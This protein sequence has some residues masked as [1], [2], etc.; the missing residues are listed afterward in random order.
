MHASAGALSINQRRLS[1]F[2]IMLRRDISV[3]IG[4]F[5]V[6]KYCV[7]LKAGL[8]RVVLNFVLA[9][10]ILWNDTYPFWPSVACYE[11]TPCVAILLNDREICRI[12]W[13]Y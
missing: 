8:V 5:G 1:S 11:K 2:L 9:L 6:D 10:L 4:G 13:M 7:L 12:C 3:F